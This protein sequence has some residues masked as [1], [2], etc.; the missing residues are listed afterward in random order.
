MR[1]RLLFA[2]E[3]DQVTDDGK[4]G[5]D[6]LCVGCGLCC[7]GT[8]FSR[9]N[10]GS[11]DQESLARLGFSFF[12]HEGEN[13]FA[14]PCLAAANGLCAIYAD[15]PHTCRTYRCALLKRQE[16]GEIGLTE[17]R[18]IIERTFERIDEVVALDPAARRRDGRTKLRAELAAALTSAPA[19]ER[20]SLGDRLLPIIA[21][22]SW[23]QAHF[24]KRED[25]A[26]ADDPDPVETMPSA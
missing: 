24:F 15:R 26:A 3:P 8:L 12:L 11:D 20:K 7:D 22:D 23:L 13:C 4:P 1:R 5:N 17:A 6:S 10:V 14:Q 21:L 19:A 16:R 9:V 2:W 25:K 18:S